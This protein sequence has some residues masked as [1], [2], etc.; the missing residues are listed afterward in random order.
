MMHDDD[1]DDDHNSYNHTD[2]GDEPGGAEYCPLCGQCASRANPTLSSPTF[3]FSE[4]SRLRTKLNMMPP[5]VKWDIISTMDNR[6][7][8]QK[9]FEWHLSLI[10]NYI[11]ESYVVNQAIDRWWSFVK[12][13]HS[14]LERKSLVILLSRIYEALTPPNRA[15]PMSRM[16]STQMDCQSFCTKA[17]T[18]NLQTFRRIMLELCDNFVNM[19]V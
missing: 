5:E 3:S 14:H 10:T 2:Q 4:A 1:G 8:S 19:N 15:C 7:R 13:E 9:R 16:F 12:N 17:K 11:Q 6:V 18:I